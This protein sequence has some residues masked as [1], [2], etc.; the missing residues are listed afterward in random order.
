M[1]PVSVASP[2]YGWGGHVY[3]LERQDPSQKLDPILHKRRRPDGVGIIASD[4]DIM[5]LHTGVIP[6][7]MNHG[8]AHDAP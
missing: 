5:H 2:R 1:A 4:D 3:P 6:G 8:E 7:W